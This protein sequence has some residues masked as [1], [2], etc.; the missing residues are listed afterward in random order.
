[1]TDTIDAAWW[2]PDDPAATDKHEAPPPEEPRTTGGA[3]FVCLLCSGPPTH[4]SECPTCGEGL[5]PFSGGPESAPRARPKPKRRPKAPPEP[6][7]E[8]QP[9]PDKP[10]RRA[11]ATL[12]EGVFAR[13]WAAT[14]DLDKFLFVQGIG[15]LRFDA[16]VWT[17]GAVAVRRDMA[18]LIHAVV[19]ETTNAA[20][21][22]RASVIEGALKMAQAQPSESRTVEVST[23]DSDP[24]AIGLPEGKILEI[25]TGK[26]RDA[27]PRDRLRKALAVAPDSEASTLWASFVYQSLSHY[28]ETERDHVANWLQE[29]CGAM[30]TGDCS[31]QKALFVW[32]EP[33]TGKSVFVET[34]RHVMGSY[35]SG[36]R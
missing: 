31:D 4:E 22:D 18:E 32:G 24:M 2:L 10:K 28:H 6:E 1:M 21:F 34:L 5:V 33:G 29:Y 9:G 16:G 35:R 14:H 30:L 13:A 17:D 36:S 26:V 12:S 8:T 20:K 15:W 19:A 23:F 27:E 11:R 25:A 3:L 7:A